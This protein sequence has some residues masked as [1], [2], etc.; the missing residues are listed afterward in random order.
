MLL[1]KTDCRKSV[2]KAKIVLVKVAFL[3]KHSEGKVQVDG[4]E[5]VDFAWLS[6]SEAIERVTDKSI[7]DN[8]IRAEQH[9]KNEDASF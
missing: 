1:K 5:E 9:L 2:L 3:T 7:K 6:F 8:L 4:F